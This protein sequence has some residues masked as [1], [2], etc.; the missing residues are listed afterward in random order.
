MP[1]PAPLPGEC[2]NAFP[3][4]LDFGEIDSFTQAFAKVRIANVSKVP[5]SL[6]VAPLEAPFSL[7]SEEVFRLEPGASTLVDV[8][9]A[10]M[11]SLLHFGELAVRARDP[12]C[13]A[14]VPL[15][16]LGSGLLSISPGF[17]DFG[18]VA[19]GE[20]KTIE[21]QFS[22]TRRISLP[23]EGLQIHASPDGGSGP[24]TFDAGSGLVLA[25]LSVTT[26]RVT[27]APVTGELFAGTLTAL[28]PFARIN[29]PVRVV[30]G[31]VVA[32]ISPTTID[33]PLAG[34]WPGSSPPSFVERSVTL[35][36]R[37]DDGGSPFAALQL[38][39]PFL[40]VEPLDDGGVEEL[41]VI[42]EGPVFGGI[43]A[44]QEA[45]LVLRFSPSALGPR[46]FL[47]TLFTNDARQPEQ[48]V[49]VSATAVSLPDC[50]LQ[51]SPSGSTFLSRT[52]DDAGS[53][54]VVTFTNVGA[55]R[56]VLDDVRLARASDPDFL[57]IDG[58]V[59][60]QELAPGEVHAVVI[61]GPAPGTFERTGSLR[62]HVFNPDSVSQQVLLHVTP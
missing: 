47:L 62:F 38:V 5:Q 49:T 43:L 1:A 10:P 6:T 12:A 15:R 39:E 32:E 21:L 25:P 35:R 34:F 56:C 45:E 4:Q 20:T 37:G 24:F 22:N 16:G 59:T 14:S 40:R 53:G 36:N 61:E 13:S 23:L 30:G 17:L 11:D 57:I 48:Q 41:E 18:V 33:V 26:L 27:A 60:Q 54:G 55:T 7:R 58:G 2:L 29:V 51:V 50:S 52:A 9:F 28:T 8:E 46:R 31:S 3:T 19:L 44:G 42:P